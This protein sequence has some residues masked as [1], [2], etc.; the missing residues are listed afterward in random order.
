[1]KE[2]IDFH[3]AKEIM[4]N[5]N[6]IIYGTI[7]NIE[8]DFIQSFTNLDILASFFKK[9]FIIIFENDSNDKTRDVL[10]SW[11]QNQKKT[12]ITKHI[13]LENNLCSLY[14][15]RATRLAYCRNKILDYIFD[16]HLEENYSYAFHCD[17]DNRFWSVDFDS[18]CNSF[19]Y[20]LDSWDVMTCVNKDK[21]YYDYWALRIDKCWFNKNI[22]SCDANWP[23]TKFETK[24]PEFIE[25]L[26]KT[27]NLLPC[28][29]S[30]NGLGI[31][32]LS[33]MKNCR[34]S[35]KYYC[36]KC[37]N[38]KKGCLED[39]DHIG[40]HQDMK[41]KNC[42]IFINTKMQILSKPKT[43]SSFHEYIKKNFLFIKNL[44]NNPLLYVLKNVLVNQNNVWLDFDTN[45][46]E[47][48]NI[49]SNYH[50]DSKV[51]SFP[52]NQ[53]KFT[54]LNKNIVPINGPVDVALNIFIGKYLK[55]DMIYFINFNDNNYFNVRS[56]L[57]K[58]ISKIA[59][60]CI[61]IFNHFINF[62]GYIQ[63]SF[64]AFFEISQEY[65]LDFET[66]G[67]NGNYDFIS[68]NSINLD[69]LSDDLFSDTIVALKIIKNPHKNNSPI[70]VCKN[71]FTNYKNDIPKP[72]NK[73]KEI[74]YDIFDWKL[75]LELNPD[76]V[77]ITNAE[78]AWYH[79][80]HNG[81]LENRNFYFDFKKCIK[82][83]GLPENMDKLEVIQ[84]FKKENNDNYKNYC[85]KFKFIQEKN[86][87][88][89]KKY[90]TELF[91]W[92][93]YVEINKDLKNINSFEKASE[94]FYNFGE[95]ENRITNDFNWLHYLFLN[96][97][98]IY[99]NILEE[100]EVVQHYLNYG[101]NEK[102]IYNIK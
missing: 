3:K 50:Y 31:Y 22:F 90:K 26:N 17:L 62:H 95:K 13:I 34:Y 76:L 100:E 81:Y 63:K 28:N 7:R 82:E 75:Y 84:K 85:M 48:A 24:I 9:T 68:N 16:N 71:D 47:P 94:H 89:I 46:G 2:T 96:P 99:H 79:W 56:I 15:L 65:N 80:Y 102:R 54:L 1:M 74:N 39:N 36:S 87:K 88:I 72:K 20:P 42:K 44:N 60:S 70:S 29:S 86:N 59:D 33:S 52:F 98:L 12:N 58:L 11:Y 91:D 35:A 27:T 45:N 49:I 53:K 67:V 32:K 57:V 101:L 78:K 23:E 4:S 19:Q 5:M 18:I 55:N 73:N 51:Y 14:P 10:N 69:D 97:D 25:L 83:Y 37:N 8:E 61:I 6:I 38:T 77:K 92:E 40:L 41:K 66:I 30:F 43:A 64:K 21:K 93:Y